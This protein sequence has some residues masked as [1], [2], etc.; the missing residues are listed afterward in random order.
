M[1]V[2]LP[3]KSARIL[4]RKLLFLVRNRLQKKPKLTAHSGKRHR[5]HNFHRFGLKVPIRAHFRLVFDNLFFTSKRY[6]N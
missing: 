3:D 6:A 2:E 4:R 1:R 5:H